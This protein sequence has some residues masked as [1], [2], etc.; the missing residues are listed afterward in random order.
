VYSV[1]SA[2]RSSQSTP[3]LSCTSARWSCFS[4]LL[5]FYC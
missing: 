5:R 4:T 2:C 3:S 1:A